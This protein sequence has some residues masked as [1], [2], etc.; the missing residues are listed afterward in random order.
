MKVRT[1]KR[2]ENSV[3][4]KPQNSLLHILVEEREICDLIQK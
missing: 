3:D 4:L 1:A 2:S